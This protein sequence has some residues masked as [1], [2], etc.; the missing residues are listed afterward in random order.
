MRFSKQHKQIKEIIQR[1]W[2]ILTDDPKVQQFVSSTPAITYKRATS[3]KGR[4][5]QSEYRG[6]SRSR[7]HSCVD[8]VPIVPL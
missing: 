2:M 8:I 3:V 1:R 5:V 7:V 6:A 4:L